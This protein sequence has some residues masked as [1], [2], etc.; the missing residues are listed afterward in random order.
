MKPPSFQYVRPDSIGDAL[1]M[2]ATHG[3]DARILA[4]GQS[5]VPAMNLRQVRPAVL[6]DVNRLPSLGG[7]SVDPEGWLRIGAVVRQREVERSPIVAEHA[8]IIAEAT[9]HIGWAQ[10]RN[11]GTFGGNLVVAAH[12]AELP[13]VSLLLGASME[14]A[15]TRGRRRICAAD[16]FLGGGQTA[17]LP[18]E[19]LVAVRYPPR[20]PRQGQG[21]VEVC[22]RAS[23]VAVVAAAATVTLDAGGRI[24]DAAVALSGAASGPILAEGAAA[25]RGL[26]PHSAALGDALAAAGAAA[27]AG[28]NVQ[29][30]DDVHGSPRYRRRLVATLTRRALAAAAAAA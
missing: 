1:V 2:L 28:R 18:D 21:F 11:R 17:L 10:I 27:A 24:A 20:A 4:G 7:I 5:L 12:H 25:L 9:A 19:M 16:F 6:V 30:C 23:G 15:S 13:A 26:D 29:P 8:P 22:R 3:A 14:V